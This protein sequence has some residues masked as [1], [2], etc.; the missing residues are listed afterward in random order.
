MGVGKKIELGDIEEELERNLKQ[1]VT[2]SDDDA[3]DVGIVDVRREEGNVFV[4]FDKVWNAK[5]CALV[6]EGTMFDGKVIDVKCIL[7]NNLPG[8]LKRSE[9]RKRVEAR[10]KK[11]KKKK[12]EEEE[13][14]EED[15]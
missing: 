13:E 10:A 6:L 3:A 1:G 4:K 14:E 11:K 9:A 12:K 2:E 15:E 8:A 7:V 5:G